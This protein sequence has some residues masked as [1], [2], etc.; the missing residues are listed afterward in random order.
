[1][2]VVLANSVR[3]LGGEEVWEVRFAKFLLANQDQVRFF[4]RPGKF[5]EVVKKEGF[6]VVEFP[7]RFDWDIFAIKKFQKELKN[8]QAELVMFNA[9]RD[10]RIGVIGAGWAGVPLKIKRSWFL[11]SSIWDKFYYNRVD[12]VVCLS[13]NIESLFKKKLGLSPNKIFYLPNGAQLERFEKVDGSRFRN[14]LGIKQDELLIGISARLEKHKRQA[15]LIQAGK[16]LVEKGYKIKIAF[17]GD[18]KNRASLEK[19]VDELRMREFVRF[20]GFVERIEEF[21]LSLDLFVFCSEFEGMPLAVLEAMASAKPIITT[22]LPGIIEI[23]EDGKDGL[24]YSVG[25]INQL[26]EKIELLI[27]DKN[28]REKIAQSARDRVE[29][30]FSETKLFEQFRQWLDRKL[31]EKR[32]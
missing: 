12:Y 17:A 31:M 18:G 24:F 8:F 23:I 21:L 3:E 15:D 28:L 7:M 16:I 6:S 19:L 5:S 1:M 4:V 30:E 26:A 20:L 13:K 9:R 2:R 14:Q 29:K 25:D 27:K 22:S 10:F 11:K 32:G